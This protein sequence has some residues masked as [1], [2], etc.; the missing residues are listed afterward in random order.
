MPTEVPTPPAATHPATDDHAGAASEEDTG[1]LT[2]W[3]LP[4]GGFAV[5]RFAAGTRA[6]GESEQLPAVYTEMDGAALNDGG[7]PTRMSWSL[8]SREDRSSR[9]SIITRLFHNVVSCFRHAHATQAFNS[10]SRSADR[11]SS[12]AVS[13]A[14]AQADRIAT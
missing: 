6:G 5:G 1:G 14:G 12:S 7:A 11:S 3:R 8:S 13:G 9:R 10:S 4:G 2:I